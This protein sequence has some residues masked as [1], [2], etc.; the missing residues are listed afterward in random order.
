M[1]R[2]VTITEPSWRVQV[3]LPDGS[4][5]VEALCDSQE[6][7]EIKWAEFKMLEWLPA[8][9]RLVFQVRGAGKTRYVDILSAQ[10]R[11]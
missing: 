3:K 9:A 8:E 4:V 1:S 7:A 10:A 11:P 5:L 6:K 2:E